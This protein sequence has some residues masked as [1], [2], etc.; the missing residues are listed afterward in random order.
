MELLWRQVLLRHIHISFAQCG[1]ICRHPMHSTTRP[2]QT[3]TVCSLSF[4]FACNMQIRFAAK[5]VHH[6]YS[7]AYSSPFSAPT[8]QKRKQSSAHTSRSG[9]ICFFVAI[10]RR[11]QGR[12][13]ARLKRSEH[14][15]VNPFLNKLARRSHCLMSQ[16]F[17][18]RITPSA[19]CQ[20]SLNN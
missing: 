18:K 3:P 10:S 14:T 2:P 6:S 19:K 16:Y 4:S 1:Q 20:N 15:R 9:F 5:S 17:A 11:T 13:S 8:Q 12:K 7:C